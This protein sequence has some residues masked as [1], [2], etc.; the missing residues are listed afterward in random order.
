MSTG[1]QSEFQKGSEWRK[2]DLH[3]HSP[4]SILNND[5]PK[6]PDGQPDW[7]KFLLKLESLDLAVV[8][9]T[10]YFTIEGYKVLRGFKEKGRLG[11]IHTILP[12]IEFRLKT[13]ISS[14]RDGEE[15]RLNLHVI[16][17]D[18]VSV[19]DIEEHFLHDLDF[20][21]EGDPQNPDQRKKLKISNLDALGKELMDQHE[22]F[23]Q[24]DLNFRKL[25]AMQAVVDDGEITDRLT[26]DKRFK[27][28]YVVIIAAD[29]WD[30]INWDG[31]AHLVRKGLLQKSDMV[32]SSSPRTRQWC[33]AKDPYK[34]GT[35]S[36]IREFKTLKPC[37][38]GSDAHRL[39]DIGHPC[40]LRGDRSHNCENNRE[41]CQLS[42]CW[43]KAD[44][45]FEGLRQVLYEPFERVAI[46]QSDPTPIKSNYTLQS[47][48]IGES[49][50]NDEL[51]IAETNLQL[52]PSLVAVAGGKGSGK[53]ALVDLIANCYMDR[54]HTKDP[55]SFVRRIT[56][57][58]PTTQIEVTFKNSTTFGKSVTEQKFFEDSDIVYIA[59]GEL[60]K[61][62]GE[63]SDLDKYIHD[64]IF[65]SA[66][67]R[68]TVR[69]FEFSSLFKE[70]KTIEARITHLNQSIYQLEQATDEVKTQEIERD[71][72]QLKAQHDDLTTRIKL[73]SKEISKEKLDIAKRQQEQL[74]NLKT[75]RDNLLRLKEL[76]G[77]ARSFFEDQLPAFNQV[78]SEANELIK[79][80]SLDQTLGELT[81]GDSDRVVTLEESLTR[82]INGASSNIENMQ[83]QLKEYEADIREH[84]AVLDR[85]RE[86][87]QKLQKLEAD[88]TKI[89]EQKKTLT[90]SVAER[91]SLFR[92]LIETVLT[93][94]EKYGEIIAAFSS[95]KDE[96]LLDLDFVAEITFNSQ[97][98]QRLAYDILDQRSATV[99]DQNWQPV[100]LRN[101]IS[102]YQDTFAEGES[103]I[104]ELIDEVVRLT[105]ELK[106]KIK[107]SEA[108]TNK[109]LLDCLWGNYMSVSPSVKYK[110]TPL[111]K[112]SLGQKASILIKIYLA[113]GTKPII[114]DSH[115]DYLDNESIMDELVKA[116][117]Q[118]KSYRQII[119]VSN[120][121]NVVINSDAEQIIIAQY[122]GQRISY[123]T[124][125]IENPSIRKKSLRVL[126]GGYKA[127]KERQQKYR[128]NS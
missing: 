70:I 31:Q 89:S 35:E 7:E 11:N 84:A 23:R 121:G 98:I 80:L 45:T 122:V 4:L 91:N 79:I 105:V 50:I 93:Q 99:Y 104:D 39:E 24:M 63:E 1:G 116:V 21:Y 26:G 42:Y 27:G 76:L 115:D 29:G 85:Q 90:W 37:V 59:Q 124:G 3:I 58:E 123:R 120:N 33:L 28:K 17:S 119:L 46:Q 14:R 95:E 40:R 102:L 82:E 128:I 22:H 38:H 32:F 87:E 48:R 94:K 2:W 19:N 73:L 51:T 52:N 55:N 114:I 20:Y 88:R 127:F 100:L 65:N 107:P 57:D 43:V 101:L 62:I 9:I 6:L 34:E 78:I 75:K 103:R 113:Q 118:A 49:I 25:G 18:E 97:R 83:K 53:T 56:P 47:L 10:D 117:R 15:K 60:E 92:K 66:Q 67:V 36:F 108:F 68:D 8:G 77:Q 41:K 72:K 30:Q 5:Y 64:S 61:Y 96:V 111:N 109:Q 54:C 106:D 13:I 125:S 81:Y 69:C 16:F 12:N 71:E 110:N 44:P 74:S 126:E 112:L 86:I